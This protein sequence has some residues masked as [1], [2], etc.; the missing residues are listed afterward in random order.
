[1]TTNRAMSGLTWECYEGIH[2]LAGLLNIISVL[3]TL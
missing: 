2:E 1:M 3:H